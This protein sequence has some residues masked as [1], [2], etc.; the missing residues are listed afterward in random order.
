MFF[1]TGGGLLVRISLPYFIFQPRETKPRIS[2]QLKHGENS[3]L[4]GVFDKPANGSGGLTLGENSD[5]ITSNLREA[6]K[7]KVSIGFKEETWGASYSL[8]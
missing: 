6:V 4:N 2:I 7:E 8:P 1:A 3:Y 5:I